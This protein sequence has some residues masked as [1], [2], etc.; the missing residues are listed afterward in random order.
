[1]RFVC[2]SCRAQYMINDEKVGPK[3]VKVRCRKCGYV[4][5]VKRTDGARGGPVATSN[6]T[7]D[8][9]ATQVMNS[10]LTTPEPSLEASLGGAEADPPTSR[11]NMNDPAVQAAMEAKAAKTAARNAEAAATASA[12]E[13]FL[14]ADEDEIGAVFDSVLSGGSTSSP[15]PPA[16]EAPKA[17]V[18]GDRDSTKV[19]DVDLVKR[20]TEESNDTGA[21][22]PEEV[23][24]QDWYVALNDK[25]TGPM[26][27]EALKGHWDTGEVGP[28]SLCWR[29]GFTDWVPVSQ[30]KLLATVLAP[31]PARPIVVAPAATVTTGLAAPSVVSVPVQSAFSAGGVVTTVQSEVQVPMA[32]APSSSPAAIEETGTWRPSAGSALASLVKE[33][34]EVLAKPATKKPEPVAESGG[35]LDLPAPDERPAAPERSSEVAAS[36]AAP[37]PPVNPYLANPGATYSAPAVTQYRPP[38]NRG[39]LIGLGVGGGVLLLS[40]IGLVAFLALREPKVVVAP[41]PVAA[42]TPPAVQGPAPTVAVAPPPG[43]PAA[44]AQPLQ[45]A[46]APGTPAPPAA[47]PVAAATP[48]EPDRAPVGASPVAQAKGAGPGRSPG[49]AKVAAV[50]PPPTRE[51]EEPAPEPV[52]EA[53]KQ[54]AGGGDGDDFDSVFGDTKKRVSKDESA[55]TAEAPKKKGGYIPPPP[56]SAGGD[57][58]EEFDKNDMMEVLLANKAGLA[59][60][61]EE[62]RKREGGGG[63]IV[64]RWTI[65]TSGAVKSVGVVTEEFKGSYMA[66]CMSAL[67]KAMK[68]PRHKKQGEPVEFPFKF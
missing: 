46:E 49:G 18:E 40:L 52:K 3:G 57:V 45:P 42:P 51:K 2:E 10:P 15:A 26:S 62:Q 47:L 21:P 19:L 53:P 58:K 35:L 8:A 16:A 9:T 66:Q 50:T 55:P 12:A 67:I 4:I 43:V 5:H 59:R 24:Q 54:A 33:E 39:L 11:V 44:A 38:S 13:S 23:P 31:K 30:V 27:L 28:D 61:A 36:R 60:C 14:G 1:M 56:G 7:D 41:A 32:A 34:L 65:D 48:S 64:M 63:K 20:L 68:F 6:D 29:A 17:P 25:Q 37:P 22:A